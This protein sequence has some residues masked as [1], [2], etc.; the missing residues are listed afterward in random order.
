MKKITITESESDG[1]SIDLKNADY[2]HA[3]ALIGA[4]Y[5]KLMM[6]AGMSKSFAHK[7]L[8]SFLNDER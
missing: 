8:N 5:C 3:V 2:A 7:Y 1:I 4:A 6:D